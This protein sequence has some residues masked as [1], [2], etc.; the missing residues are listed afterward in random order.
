MSP[1]AQWMSP[2]S[3]DHAHPQADD[4][5][6]VHR[7][8]ETERKRRDKRRGIIA[9]SLDDDPD[10]LGVLPAPMSRAAKPTTRWS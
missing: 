9:L 4:G 7:Q 2:H 8:L 10:D 1:A 5:G 3:R 6:G